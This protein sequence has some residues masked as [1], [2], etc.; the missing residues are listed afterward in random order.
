MT[1]TIGICMLVVPSLV[2]RTRPRNRVVWAGAVYTFSW[3]MLLWHPLTMSGHFVKETLFGSPEL[4]F[5]N[6]T[7]PLLPWFSLNLAASAL[8]DRLGIWHLNG[9]WDRMQGLLNRTAVCA[10]IGA[11]AL[12]GIHSAA[13][14]LTVNEG[15]WT[16]LRLLTLPFQKEPP[17]PAYLLFYGAIGLGM[18]SACLF[19]ERRGLCRGFASRT[20]V[21]GQTSLVAF[22]AQ[23]Y[24]FYTALEFLLRNRLLTLA[25]PVYFLVSVAAVFAIALAWHRRGYDRFITVGLQHAAQTREPGLYAVH[26]GAGP[27]GG[28][29]PGSRAIA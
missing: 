23:Y 13:S 21:L 24:V 5:Y 7:F 15:P 16:A 22:V 25:W 1:D 26:G 3:I 28:R 6:Y 9:R 4:T 18:I 29:N 27:V 8:G 17:S 14:R 12:V 19:C 20:I 11:T 10:F 2:A